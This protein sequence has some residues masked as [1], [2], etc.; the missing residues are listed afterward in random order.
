METWTFFCLLRIK[1]YICYMEIDKDI[2][3]GCINN[4]RLSQH[5]LYK[6]L[7]GFMLQIAFKYSNDRDKAVDYMNVGFYK[8]LRKIHLYDFKTPFDSWARVIIKN[9]I[10]DEYRKE[11]KHK[12]VCSLDK[13][14]YFIGDGMEQ[15]AI[16]Y[17][18]KDFYKSTENLA[19]NKFSME[20]VE[21]MLRNL[22]DKTR[23]V[24]KMQILEGFTHEQIAKILGIS[25][26]ASKWHLV[27]G[28]NYL[29]NNLVVSK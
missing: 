27:Q 17:T 18:T 14:N 3:V 28:K 5:K 13:V 22:G 19:E 8:L 9:A 20:R 15:E 7:H 16:E 4:D 11:I 24:I 29:R 12:N 2:L 25:V 26:S 23:E 6:K 10:I 1:L 21:Y